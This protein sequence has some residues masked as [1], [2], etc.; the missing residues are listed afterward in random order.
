LVPSHQEE[1]AGPGFFCVAGF[2]LCPQGRAGIVLGTGFVRPASGFSAVDQTSNQ[3]WK[4]TAMNPSRQQE[5]F[6]LVADVLN[7]GV[8]RVNR[9]TSPQQ[10]EGWDSVQHLNIVLALEQA[11]GVQ[12]SP[13][14]IEKMQSVGQIVDV[15]DGKSG[16]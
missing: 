14:E 16:T 12:F 10:I 3:F 8:E 1:R 5:I 15:I 11:M 4:N 13:E 6:Q 9:E 7:V 2:L